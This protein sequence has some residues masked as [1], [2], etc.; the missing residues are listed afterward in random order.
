MKLASMDSVLKAANDADAFAKAKSLGLDGI[1]INLKLAGLRDPTSARPT[2]LRELAA[3]HDLDLASMVL[4]E[5]NSGG[6]ATWWRDRSADDE[7]RR[8][9]EWCS[10]I[11][12]Q[13]LLLPFFFFNEPKGRTHRAAVAERLKPHC[14]RAAEL[15]VVIAFEGVLTAEQLLE[16]ANAI[17]SPGFGVYYDPAN[18]TWCDHDVASE[19][20]ALGKL[21]RQMHIKDAKTFTGDVPA[22]EGRVDW[23][24]VVAALD[25]I[26][27]DR[28]LS[29]ETPPG[30]I[31]SIAKSVAFARK[32]F[33]R[34]NGVVNA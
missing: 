8:A 25:A 18:A 3:E 22:G 34:L 4:G 16:M 32:T 9:V 21:I 5:H 6:I 7:V 24:G 12:A 10:D 31:E 23:K 13:T 26:G 2:R 14:E 20:R 27:F 29:L 17:D 1:E 19:I 15:K 30:P 28:W 33:P 11:G